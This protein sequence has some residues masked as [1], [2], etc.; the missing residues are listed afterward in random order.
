MIE[1]KDNT[2]VF[3]EDGTLLVFESREEFAGWAKDKDNYEAW[4]E[5]K[6][7]LHVLREYERI[8]SEMG[9]N[10]S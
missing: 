9:E 7:L 10:E 6:W 1:V 4:S 3:L 8:I 2:I 5:P